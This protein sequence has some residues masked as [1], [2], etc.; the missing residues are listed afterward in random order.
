VTS[1]AAA[2]EEQSTVTSEMSSSMHRAA[3][4]LPASDDK[5]SQARHGRQA[6]QRRRGRAGRAPA[7]PATL[8][9]KRNSAAAVH[10]SVSTSRRWFDQRAGFHQPAEILLV[11]M[12]A[13]IA[14]TVRCSSV[15]VNSGG[16]SSNTGA[17]FQ[18]GAQPR[19]GR[20]QNAPVVEPHRHSEARNR[21]ARQRAPAVP[22]A[23]ST[24][25][26]R[27]AAHNGRARAPRPVAASA[28]K[29]SR[30]RSLRPRARRCRL[31]ACAA[32]RV[33]S[34][35]C[36]ARSCRAAL[37]ANLPTERSDTRARSRAGAGEALSARASAP[38]SRS[39]RHGRRCR[40]LGVPAAIAEGI[41]LLDIA[42]P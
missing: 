10:R 39:R 32:Q 4:R 15:R 33:S 41:E 20:G 34:E 31:L 40:R 27:R 25:P 6:R 17:V 28:P 3:A 11:Q 7:A 26:A 23:S 19:D 22:S 1:T 21:L 12:P 35:G 37:R 16:R 9:R 14:S 5:P 38:G 36:R 8:A 42:E 18:F 2:V 13:E 24:N 30:T 29:N